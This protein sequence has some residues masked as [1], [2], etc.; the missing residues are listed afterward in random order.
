MDV[1][2][3][4]GRSLGTASGYAR[5]VIERDPNIPGNV[6]FKLDDTIKA[7]GFFSVRREDLDDVLKAERDPGRYR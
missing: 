4:Y 1:A 7:A 5:L 3:N 6:R 2:L